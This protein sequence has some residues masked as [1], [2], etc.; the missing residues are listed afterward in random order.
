MDELLTAV[1]EKSPHGYTG[2]I[3]EFP[4]VNTQGETLEETRKHLIEAL[5]LVLQANR[6]LAEEEIIANHQDIM[7]YPSGTGGL[8][9]SAKI[10]LL[11]SNDRSTDG[12]TMSDVSR[13]FLSPIVQGCLSK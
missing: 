6:E 10:L 4:G 9:S 2:Y 7:I 3:E 8:L 5:E 12:A 13:L 1:F 11:F